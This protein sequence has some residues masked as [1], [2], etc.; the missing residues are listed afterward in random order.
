MSVKRTVYKIAEIVFG[1]FLMALAVNLV[2]E[3]M[4]MVT[5][6]VSGLA[7]AVKELTGRWIKGGIPVWLTNFLVNI[8]IFL[9]GYQTKGKD[10]LRN[11]IFANICFSIFLLALPVVTISHK[12]YFLSAVLGGV[13]TGIGLGCVFATGSSTGGTDLLSS[14]VHEYFPLYPVSKLLFVFDAVIILMGAVIFG[15]FSTSYAVIAVFLT[16]KIMDEILS[17]LKVGKQIWII[18][19][20]YQ[21]ISREIMQQIDRGVTGVEARGMYTDRSKKM[22]FCVVEKRQVIPVVDIVRKNDERAFV[23]IQDVREIMGEGFG[24]NTGK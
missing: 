14:I 12:D 20:K 22:L 2:Y 10:F 16:S 24:K 11:T 3:P 6:G 23:I 19:D 8:P 13:L 17:G 21:K 5:G 15:V 18:S 9:W 4:H 7:I 1:T